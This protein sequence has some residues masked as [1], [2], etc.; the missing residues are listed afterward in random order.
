MISPP[1]SS[2]ADFDALL[3]QDFIAFRA[4][5]VN[6]AEHVVQRRFAQLAIF[7]KLGWW[8]LNVGA[9]PSP[10][11]EDFTTVDAALGRFL[12]CAFSCWGPSDEQGA[13][14][15]GGDHCAM[16]LPIV[17][18]SL[19]D[20]SYTHAV[21]HVDRV[22]SRTGPTAYQHAA[23]LIT[24]LANPN[25]VA[26]ERALMLA[27]S[28]VTK[29]H[30]KVCDRAFVQFF[31]SILAQDRNA[32]TAAF[33]AF[34]TSY[35]KSDWGK[36]RPYTYQTTLHALHAYASHYMAEP[37]HHNTLSTVLPAAS[38]GFWQGYTAHSVTQQAQ[39][40][41]TGVLT[42]LNVLPNYCS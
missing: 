32:V 6:V 41:F 31:L 37:I 42:F 18:S 7:P 16:V 26:R 20:L 36:F 28:Y 2:L 22:I 8:L 13:H 30:N 4:I 12:N 9:P 10:I 21:F 35:L 1:F 38:V 33:G 17:Y 25:W 29:A 19:W 39:S 5:N 11:F 40:P 3:E 23:N 24:L 15:G 27:N 34:A 14:W